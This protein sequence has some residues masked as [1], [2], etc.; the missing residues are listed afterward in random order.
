MR[1][2]ECLW[3]F[4]LGSCSYQSILYSLLVLL[5]LPSQRIP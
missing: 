3:S 1:A 4:N 5:A 2:I